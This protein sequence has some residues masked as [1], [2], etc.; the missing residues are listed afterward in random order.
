MPFPVSGAPF[1]FRSRSAPSPV[2][3][4]VGS[5]VAHDLPLHGWESTSSH[6]HDRPVAC[7]A[8]ALVAGGRA[9]RGL[10]AWAAVG[11]GSGPGPV[12]NGLMFR[13]IGRQAARSCGK[14]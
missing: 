14:R 5:A 10:W 9:R 1:P 7:G 8:S 11:E 3:G 2:S 4:S 6:C 13:A 12:L